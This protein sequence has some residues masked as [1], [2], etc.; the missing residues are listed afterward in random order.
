MS[1]M[2]VEREYTADGHLQG[3][4]ILVNGEGIPLLP[5]EVRQQFRNDLSEILLAIPV[6][7]RIRITIETLLANL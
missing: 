6:G 4:S 2:K 3:G 5:A 1:V 7:E